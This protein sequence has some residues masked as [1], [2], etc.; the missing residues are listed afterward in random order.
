MAFVVSSGSLRGLSRAYPALPNYAVRLADDYTADY[1]QIWRTQPAVRT[2]V[3]FLARNIASLG[4]HLFRRLSDTDRERLTDHPAA[5]LLARPAPRTT[6]YRLINSLVH[7]LGIYDVGY[8]AKILDTQQQALLRLPPARTTPVGQ[9]WLWPDGF[10]FRGSTGKRTFPSEQVV[11]FHGYDPDDELT[12]CSPIE[13]LRRTLAEEYE[14]GRMREQVLRNGARTSGYLQRPADAP[15]WA[16][17]ARDRFR[18]EW[19][20]QYAGSGPQAGGTPI[21]EDGMVFVPAAQTA[22][23]LQYIQARKLTR[24]EVAAAYHIPPPMVGLLDNA[25]FSNIEQQHRMLYQDTLGPWLTMICE[26]IGL[27]L[28]PDFPDVGQ[29]YVE[30]N[31][32][33]KLRGSFEEQAAQLQTSVG[34]PWLTR[35]EA[36]ARMNLSSIDGGDELVVPLNVIIG[37]QASPTDSAPEQ[38]SRPVAHKAGG[39]GRAKGKSQRRPT[40]DEF[41]DDHLQRVQAFFARQSQAVRS[42]IGAKGWRPPG[43][44]DGDPAWWNA[45]RWDAELAQEL[46]DLAVQVSQVSALATLSGLD[47]PPDAYDVDRTIAYLHAVTDGAASEINATTR[48]NLVAALASDD[49]AAGVADVFTTADAVRAG[50]IATT[51]VTRMIGFGKVEAAHQ[52]GTDGATKTW[53]TGHNA[54]PSHARMDGET[55]PLDATFSNGLA[56][57][58]AIGDPDETAG[59]NC[60]VSVNV[61]L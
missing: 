55:V 43:K 1:A 28:L 21:L 15:K 39:A 33:E 26:E 24:E 5:A 25:T 59:C 57:P 13:S 16:A 46:Y 31:L 23:Q 19:Q 12:G 52:L 14:A 36:R 29:V 38:L 22:E 8:W 34:A 44:A 61:T 47:L 17:G 30:F 4:L 32:A 7:D 42:A 35:N 6:R 27:Q 18:R 9:N 45:A 40:L 10:E 49:P 54:R 2:V 41:Y 53:H 51:A 56:W 60:E 58:G 3:S 50:V 37:G 20:A 48:D 11:F